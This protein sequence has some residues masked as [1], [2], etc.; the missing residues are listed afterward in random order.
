[1]TLRLSGGLTVPQGGLKMSSPADIPTDPYWDDVLLLIRAN[2]TNDGYDDLSTYG[3]SIGV[4][5]TVP[6]NTTNTKFGKSI[7]LSV[8]GYNTGN[9]LEWASS[10]EFR[11]LFPNGTAFTLETWAY[12]I[13][14]AQSNNFI[15]PAGSSNSHYDVCGFTHLGTGSDYYI[16]RNGGAYIRYG[17]SNLIPTTQ[18]VHL[19][20]TRETNNTTRFYLDGNRVG[21]SVTFSPGTGL[22][23]GNSR[24]GRGFT[25]SG[26][27]VTSNCLYE[28]VRVTK[29]VA[30]YTGETYDVPSEPFPSTGP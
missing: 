21:N 18:W 11:Q 4:Q 25:I 9:Y 26:G 2:D 19:A 16:S 20:I 23:S 5:G 8:G 1:M 14:E 13:S 6:V 27:Y 12:L 30:R 24:L 29:D 3:R 17:N 7:D 15:A 10:L 28:E 22:Q